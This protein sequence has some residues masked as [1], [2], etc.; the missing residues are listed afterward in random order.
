MS[1]CGLKPRTLFVCRW[2]LVYELAFTYSAMDS[3]CR[4]EQLKSEQLLIFQQSSKIRERCA[5]T[6]VIQ[7]RTSVRFRPCPVL[8]FFCRLRQLQMTS[9]GVVLGWSNANCWHLS[10]CP[11]SNKIFHTVVKAVRSL[12]VETC[13]GLVEHTFC[14]LTKSQWHSCPI[15]RDW[16]SWPGHHSPHALSKKGFAT[17]HRLVPLDDR[18]PFNSASY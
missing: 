14:G 3:H 4:S 9:N 7:E 15:L 2:F 1:L 10:I 16:N 18:G 5:S 17:D 13:M 6:P 12:D 8:S 11:L